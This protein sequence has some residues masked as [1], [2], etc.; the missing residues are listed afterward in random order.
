[1]DIVEYGCFW[2]NFDMKSSSVFKNV[3]EIT[4]Y[5]N[6]LWLNKIQ[7][8]TSK[9]RKKDQP[10]STLLGLNHFSTESYINGDSALVS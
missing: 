5:L 6:K 10:T 8:D 3:I 9:E 4:F 2:M 1:M 7:R